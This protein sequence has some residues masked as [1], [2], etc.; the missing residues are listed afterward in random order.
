MA[1]MRLDVG[2]RSVHPRQL[3]LEPAKLLLQVSGFNV[4]L[5]ERSKVEWGFRLGAAVTG[6][7]ADV[8]HV[9][10]SKSPI[11]VALHC[12]T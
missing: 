12:I 8:P 9:R 4:F 11:L 1:T 10:L 6:A 7:G 5:R 3:S 2:T